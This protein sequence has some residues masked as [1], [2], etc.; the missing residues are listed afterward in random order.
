MDHAVV[1]LGGEI[2]EIVVS[3]INRSVVIMDLIMEVWSGGFAGIADLGDDVSSFDFLPYPHEP[4][5]AMGIEGDI[6]EAMINLDGLSV[7][8]SPTGVDDGTITGSEDLRS[9]RCREIHTFMEAADMIDGVYTPSVTGS[10]SL[11]VLV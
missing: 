10:H 1:V 8:L 11:E 2:V 5:G 9:D 4:F 6:M 3:G 7:A